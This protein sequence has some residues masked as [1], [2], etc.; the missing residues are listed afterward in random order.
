VILHEQTHATQKHSLDILFIELLQIV[1]W[2]NPFLYFIKHSIKL[3]HEFLADRAVLNKGIATSTY[4]NILLAFSSNAHT[5]PLANS[6]NYSST[7]LIE[8]FTKQSFGQVKKRFTIMKT[9]TSKRA[10]W[11]RTLLLLPLI[12]LVLYGFSNREI[13]KLSGSDI[14]K[15]ASHLEN[16]DS[17]KTFKKTL[18]VEIRGNQITVNG[19]KTLLNRFAKTVDEITNNWDEEELSGCRLDVVI[20]N[21][22]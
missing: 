22:N 17:E 12:T 16:N 14:Q 21:G 19:R 8:L 13:K 6:I 11:L 9:H 5:P 10:V 4:Q 18:I 7:R 15:T 20:K 3:N 2:F 1:F